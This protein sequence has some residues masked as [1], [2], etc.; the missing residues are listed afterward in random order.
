MIKILEPFALFSLISILLLIAIY[1]IKPNYKSKEISSVYIWNEALKFLKRKRRYNKLISVLLFI[2]QCLILLCL[3]FLLAN[4]LVKIKKDNKEHSIFL[5]DSSLNMQAGIDA[6]DTRFNRAI[7]KI[8][9]DS[10]DKI[11]KGGQVTLIKV[12]TTP[13]IL[14]NFEEDE[15]K[16]NDVLNK[17]EISEESADIDQA[18]DLALEIKK[19][20]ENSCIS[21]YT[22]NEYKN[23]KGIKVNNISN[24]KDFNISILDAKADFIDGY[25]QVKASCLSNGKNSNCKIKLTFYEHNHLGHGFK[26]EFIKKLSL[27]SNQE[28]IIR[29]DN[30]GIFDFEKAKI[31]VAE[32]EGRT[33]FDNIKGDNYF[34]FFPDTKPLLKV[35]YSSLRPNIFIKGA[36]R[37]QKKNYDIR[38]NVVSEPEQAET[39]G[40]DLYIYEHYTPSTVPVDGLVF[41]INPDKSIFPNIK[42][43]GR[44]EGD[45]LLDK[46][47]SHPL[48][49]N[50]ADKKIKCTAYQALRISGGYQSLLSIQGEDV[51][52]YI[53][54]KT[55]KVIV[56]GLDLNRSDFVIQPDFPFFF[57]KI[58]DY[59]LPLPITKNTFN[60]NEEVNVRVRDY[61]VKIQKEGKSNDI[62]LKKDKVLSFSDEGLY[63][64]EESLLASNQ[65]QNF[66][67]RIPKIESLI[68]KEKIVKNYSISEKRESYYSLV[69]PISIL[70]FALLIFERVLH[71]VQKG[72]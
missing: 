11:K 10:L 56:L 67:V 28:Q 14:F 43:L 9:M 47:L 66:F 21:L 37:V 64:L 1:L 72:R 45:F 44:R 58:F 12:S 59:F 4:P 60:T 20:N 25:Y 55:S 24:E 30:T 13:E 6:K 29:F 68:N 26:K 51:C 71:Y 5:L 61:L 31:E 46:K 3:S 48:T 65:T 54:T 39:S 50:I 35:Q 32:C 62:K 40:Y 57:H 70:A 63:T 16:I 17:I 52:A 8:R 34:W 49:Q 27:W 41:F 53:K 22:S 7:E 15:E 18:I 36:V 42:L 19:K 2:T 23:L 38:M 69:F 33:D